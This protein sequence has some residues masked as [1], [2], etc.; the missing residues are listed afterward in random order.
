MSGC[1][2]MLLR[3]FPLQ[4][5]TDLSCIPARFGG[6]VYRRCAVKQVSKAKAS[7]DSS[8]IVPFVVCHQPCRVPVELF[9]AKQIVKQHSKPK[10]SHIRTTNFPSKTPLKH[11]LLECSTKAQ[12]KFAETTANLPHASC[13]ICFPLLKISSASVGLARI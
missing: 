10:V 7:N 8:P 3:P 5:I 13:V 11:G 2:S 12:H 9:W 1:Q 6:A 4:P